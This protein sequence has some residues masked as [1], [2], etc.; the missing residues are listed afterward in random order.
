MKNLN[1]LRFLL[2]QLVMAGSIAIVALH[3]NMAIAQPTATP[4]DISAEK[5][6][7]LEL[8]SQ[9]VQ[10]DT[11]SIGGSVTGLTRGSAVG[12]VNNS[13]NGSDN[14]SVQ[15]NGLFV[16]PTKIPE[17]PYQIFISRQ[18]LGQSC[19]VINGSGTASTNVLDI[20]VFCES[21]K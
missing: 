4:A 17:G 19:M 12:L 20:Q 3:G 1:Q 8:T 2:K 9:N 16:F 21:R 15:Q 13:N 11:Y 14:L 10:G 5:T 6:V 18:P 7:R